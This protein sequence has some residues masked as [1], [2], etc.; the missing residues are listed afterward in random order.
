MNRQ[1]LTALQR[2]L[3]ANLKFYDPAKFQTIVAGAKGAEISGLP[4][5]RNQ[6]DLLLLFTAVQKVRS[7]V[8]I[9]V[10]SRGRMIGGDTFVLTP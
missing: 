7:S 8:N 2:D 4:S 3:K 9:V 10:E 6:S 1:Q 5:T